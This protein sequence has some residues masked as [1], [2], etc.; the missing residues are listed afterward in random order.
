MLKLYYILN[1]ILNTKFTPG[2][3]FPPI[4]NPWC[5][6]RIVAIGRKVR[7][8][9]TLPFMTKQRSQFGCNNRQT[10]QEITESLILNSNH[11]KTSSC[12]LSTQ[13]LSFS[14]HL[15][16]R[17]DA[18]VDTPMPKERLLGKVTSKIQIYLHW[19]KPKIFIFSSDF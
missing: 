14:R 5:D 11:S 17:R 18:R 19:T 12:H 9:H 10:A 2:W 8:H 15:C 7:F 13:I 6:A 16:S 3:E 4:E 1:K